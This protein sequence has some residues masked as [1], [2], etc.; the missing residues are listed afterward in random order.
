MENYEEITDLLFFKMLLENLED[1]VRE[2][3]EGTIYI[4]Y[5]NKTKVS[6]NLSLDDYYDPTKVP[7]LK[8]EFL[9]PNGR[10]ILLSFNMGINKTVINQRDLSQEEISLFGDVLAQKFDDKSNLSM[11]HYFYVAVTFIS[12]YLSRK[13][14]ESEIFSAQLEIKNLKR[15]IEQSNDV[16]NGASNRLHKL[17]E[18]LEKFDEDFSDYLIGRNITY[19]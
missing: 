10:G 2:M 18:K 17:E 6:P 4:N 15:K 19:S 13:K 1:I 3:G 11:Y 5:L 16:I 7:V 14:I 12:C 8:G 9:I